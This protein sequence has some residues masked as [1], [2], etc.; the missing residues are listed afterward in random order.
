MFSDGAQKAHEAQG[1]RFVEGITIGI[2]F[3]HRYN[4]YPVAK[5]F[6]H[7]MFCSLN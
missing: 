6:C 7:S 4:Q 2:D 3:H 5:D 1:Y